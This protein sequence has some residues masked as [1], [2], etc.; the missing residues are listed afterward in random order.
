[1][2]KIKNGR[3]LTVHYDF[4]ILRAICDSEGANFAVKEF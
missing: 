3:E 4:G 2:S 1:M